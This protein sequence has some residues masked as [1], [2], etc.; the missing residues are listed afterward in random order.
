[1]SAQLMAL[2]RELKTLNARKKAGEEL[3]I[4]DE[5]RRKE[6]KAFLKTQLDGAEDSA[7]KA[8]APAAASRAAPA[9]VPPPV[10]PQPVAPAPVV[11]PPRPVT[12]SAPPPSPAPVV[13]PPPTAPAPPK[14]VPRKDVFAISGADSFIDAAMNSEAVA[15]TDPWAARKA[16]ASDGDLADAEAKADAA[17]R[18]NRK[19]ERAVA[20]EDVE[21][22]LREARSGYTPQA[23]S[24]CLEQYYGDY[25]SD[26][27]QPAAAA[28]AVELRPLD[29]RELEVR[30]AIDLATSSSAGATSVA[31][32]AGLAFL[33]DFPALYARRILPAPSA[34]PSAVEVDDPSMLIGSRKVTV[35]LVNGEKKQGAIRGLK[36]GE[37]G[38]K[39]ET[40]GASEEIAISQV[41]A[42]FV[43]LQPNAAVPPSS[44]KEI[45]V[46]FRD[47]R[48]VQGTSLDYAPQAP[49][50]SLVPP[51]GRGQFEKIIIN[52]GA[53]ASVS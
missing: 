46:M 48:A 43:H 6:L 5:A 3:S 28:E 49:V 16:H 39:L 42:V 24:Y 4:D 22:Q 23:D 7:A 13:A 41:K 50:F 1:M 33:D 12:M 21:A 14:F 34:G 18:A 37:L 47:Q 52:A 2:V 53:V 17:I 9:P 20:P 26:G 45:T 35:H 19:R 30:R 8:P 10:A 27:L 44:G 15:R 36:R 51:A 40:G 25:F 31:V 38:F 32:P 11:A 29:P